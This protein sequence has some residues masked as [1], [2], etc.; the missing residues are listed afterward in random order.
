MNEAEFN[1]DAIM[2]EVEGV[3]QKKLLPSPALGE[4]VDLSSEMHARDA[5]AEF[6]RNIQRP[7]VLVFFESNAYILNQ[8]TGRDR[9]NLFK[10][11]LS[12][13]IKDQ[14]AI[15]R[16]RK[17]IGEA[18]VLERTGSPVVSEIIHKQIE[19][20]IKRLGGQMSGT[21]A[22]RRIDS[23]IKYL[24]RWDKLC[25]ELVDLERDEGTP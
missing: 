16:S 25:D 14:A 22:Y 23:R 13:Y 18:D 15:L 3:L 4:S 1:L 11:R 20:E 2:G 5:M 10:N 9:V 6:E 12:S 17:K 7:Y 8:F 24:D 19:V 21:D